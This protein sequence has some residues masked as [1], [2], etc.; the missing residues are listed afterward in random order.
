MNNRIT[1]GMDLGDKKHVAC[2]L[3]AEG[4]ETIRTN[5]VNTPKAIMKCMRD[6]PHATVAIEACVHSPWISRLLTELGATV[7]VG[8]PRKLRCI[9]DADD[10]TDTR[11]ARMLARIARFDPQLL[12]PITHRSEDAQR[13]LQLIKA[14]D[15]L[16]NART[17]LVNSVR[18]SVKVLGGRVPSGWSARS[19]ASK[20]AEELSEEMLMTFAPLLEAIQALTDRITAYDKSI[21]QLAEAKY[22]ETGRLRQVKGVGA[23]TALAYILTIDDPSRFK[24]SRDVGPYLGLVPKR[25]QSGDTDKQLHITKAGNTY[26]RQLLV[27]CAHYILGPFGED[28]DLRRHGEKIA[29]RGG[30]NAKKRAVVAVTRKLSVL[31]H[32]LWVSG[33]KY[34]PLRNHGERSKPRPESSRPARSAAKPRQPLVAHARPAAAAHTTG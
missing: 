11:D 8:N 16:V 4:N 31:L 29:A 17:K 23:I 15:A 13:D 1:I 24:K 27:G 6:F 21:E 26:L 33:E 19:F 28:C 12:S 18:S 32:R 7:Y 5:I 25:D 22:P 34:E 20:A 3:D 2:I 14:R 30:K 9:W 10:K